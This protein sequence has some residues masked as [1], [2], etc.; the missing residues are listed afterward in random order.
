MDDQ[1]PLNIT[2]DMQRFSATGRPYKTPATDG[3]AMNALAGAETWGAAPA[4]TLPIRFHDDSLISVPV[5]RPEDVGKVEAE[6][7][8]KSFFT[9]RRKSSN[10][11]FTIKQVPRRDYLKHYAKDDDGKYC[12]SEAPA[13]DCILRGEDAAKYCKAAFLY[14]SHVSTSETYKDQ[15]DNVIR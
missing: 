14:K 8:K 7:P 6:K 15:K 13:E 11:N 3:L 5:L 2:D 4:N 9:S 12:G 10:A 1:K